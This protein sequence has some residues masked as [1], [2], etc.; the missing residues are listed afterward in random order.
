MVLLVHLHSIFFQ[1]MSRL[2]SGVLLKAGHVLLYGLPSCSIQLAQVRIARDVG[3]ICNKGNL[4]E[5]G[6][7][8]VNRYER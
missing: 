3:C 4:A 8:S 7:G 5:K 1:V 2:G 6:G